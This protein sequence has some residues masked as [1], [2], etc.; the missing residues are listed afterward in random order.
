MWVEGLTWL[1]Q[2]CD[3]H[4]EGGT[5]SWSIVIGTNVAIGAIVTIGA[6][7]AIDFFGLGAKSIQLKG[8]KYLTLGPTRKSPWP[9][10]RVLVLVWF[11]QDHVQQVSDGLLFPALPWRKAGK[12]KTLTELKIEVTETEKRQ[13]ASSAC[14]IKYR[15]VGKAKL[16]RGQPH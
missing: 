8:N 6:R 2:K 5:K 15:A 9:V 11:F 10:E 13:S 16:I 14:Q 4:F 12:W 7:C 3:R 1:A